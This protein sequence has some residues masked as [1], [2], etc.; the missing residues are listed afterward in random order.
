MAY[1]NQQDILDA[2]SG[3]LDIIY[4]CFPQAKEAQ[5]KAD[6]RFKI[7]AD[8]KTA[9]AS[10]KKLPDGIWVATDFG[11]DQT[12]R[13]GI[14]VYQNEE[15]LTYRE[16]LVELASIYGIGGI[17][18]EV[19]KAVFEKR[20]A[21]EDEKEGEYYFEIKEDIPEADLKVLGP[22]VTSEICRRYSCFSLISFTYIKNRQAQ[23]TTATDTYPIFMFD[24]GEFKKLYQ[25]LNPEK[26]YRFRYVGKKE[27]DYV[28]GLKQLNKAYNDYEQKQLNAP[29]IDE[30]GKEKKEK[31]KKLEAAILCSGERDALNVAG[32]GYLPVWLN[33]ETA[34]L[35]GKNY[36]AIVRCCETFYNL[37]DIDST[38]VKAAVELGMK[39][40][41]IHHIWLPDTLRNFKDNRNKPRKD[42]LD[43]IEIYRTDWD[44][45]KLINVAKPMRFWNIDYTKG[46]V[47]YKISS[48]NTRFFLQSNG[49][50]QLENKNSK[51]GQMF[52]K[53]DGHIVREIQPK[54]IKGFLINY[55][56]NKYLSLDVLELVLNTNRLSEATLQGLKQV[57]L[58]FTDYEETS[59]FLFFE[60]KV[61]KITK[62]D[63]F[64]SR[65]EQTM[66]RYVWQEELIPHKVKKQDP[67]FKITRSKTGE[68]D[69]EIL[70]TDSHYFAFL[71]NASRIHW[72]KEMEAGKSVVETEAYRKANP[73]CINGETLT[74]AEVYEQKQHLINKIFSLGYLLHRHKSQSRAWAV[75]A[76]D[77]ILGEEGESNGRSGKS[78][79]YK[80]L[81]HLMKSVT[82][83]GRNPKLT[84]N[85][86]LYDRVTEHTDYLLVDDADQ[87]LNYKFFF[88]SI[89][90]EL[91]VNPKNN[92]S[93]EIPF[94]CSPKFCFTSN[95][96]MR[97]LD[98]SLSARILYTVF[99]DYYHEST[100]ENNYRETRKIQHD[101]GKDLF[102]SQYTE[103]EWN[104]DLNFFAQC[105]KFFFNVPA[106]QIINPPMGNVNL[107][108][109]L[110]KMTQVFKDWADAYFSFD[111]S[112]G[113]GENVNEFI[114]KEVAMKDFMAST[115]QSKW[116][117]NKF[118]SSL[119]AFC[120]FYGYNFNPKEFQNAQG[121][122]SRKDEG[123]TKD[124][125]YIQTTNKI[126][127][128]D[129]HDE[130]TSG[131]DSEDAPF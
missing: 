88:D 3:G 102:G 12:P 69:I 118:T 16:A 128:E 109:L 73:F 19:N 34:E 78:F 44:F 95:H 48:T 23:V 17:E 111:P 117:T 67:P 80:A 13:N 24:H 114:V 2:T 79:G 7:R 57:E 76:M 38:G 81:R 101:F 53:I 66:D 59:Q 62:D 51:T 89:T 87:Y 74:E 45:K 50:Y 131:N 58:D 14:Q 85:P 71:V 126:K 116:S 1:I 31:I 60:N 98:T 28:N 113:N 18:S 33:S 54:D 100:E 93:Y 42:F 20:Q 124:M 125:I 46:G 103:T 36:K 107:R 70:N 121:R 86:H 37:P 32:Y 119:R 43:Y 104:Y 105:V 99:S 6:K 56:E 90:G 64:E 94:E 55:C 106:P 96:A 26:Q 82:L 22:K 8:E 52:V 123:K 61:W 65:P 10:L 108:N 21:T 9:S 15:N 77:N 29:A 75:F 110:A 41:D 91:I 11:G 129:L 115:N 72:R 40:L 92:Q 68:Y 49:F 120:Q 47:S 83:S 27:K 35:T 127:P 5:G 97:D 30:N 39:Y 25:P 4:R 122:I 84:D 112:T 130:N 63:I